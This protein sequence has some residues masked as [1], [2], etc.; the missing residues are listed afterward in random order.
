MQ[1]FFNYIFL[2]GVTTIVALSP[3]VWSS[4]IRLLLGKALG[5][6]KTEYPAESSF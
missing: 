4:E 2:V 1:I 3:N 5:G 6:R